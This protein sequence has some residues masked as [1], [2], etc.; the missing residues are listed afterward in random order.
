MFIDDFVP[1]RNHN[2]FQFPRGGIWME[3]RHCHGNGKCL[4]VERRPLHPARQVRYAGKS[5]ASFIHL[6][7]YSFVYLFIHRLIHF[8]SF[9]VA[10]TKLVAEVLEK[11]GIDGAVSSL[12]C[13]DADVGASM[14]KDPRIPLLSFTGSTPVGRQVN[15]WRS[16]LGYP[17]RERT[18]IGVFCL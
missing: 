18:Q 8:H 17:L 10:I 12:V 4:L 13:G 9:S 5:V 2:G 11:N 16:F 14:A 3:R 1:F 7:I 15:C 6:C